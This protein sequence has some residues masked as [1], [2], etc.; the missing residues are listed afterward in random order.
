[1]DSGLLENRTE[2]RS[3]SNVGVGDVDEWNEEGWRNGA[4]GAGVGVGDGAADGVHVCHVSVWLPVLTFRLQADG[5]EG[6]NVGG[7]TSG[8]IANHENHR[9][10]FVDRGLQMLLRSTKEHSDRRARRHGGCGFCSHSSR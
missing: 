10:C 4:V 3:Q 5:M 8:L 9:L 2:F 1:M 7:S 6:V